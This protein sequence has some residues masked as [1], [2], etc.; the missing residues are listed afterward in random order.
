MLSK[1]IMQNHVLGSDHC[2]C[3]L[4]AHHVSWQQGRGMV[5][6]I[7][8][9]ILFIPC[10]LFA[11]HDL[12]QAA[13]SLVTAGSSVDAKSAI[14]SF[15]EYTT[16]SDLAQGVLR[17]VFG[18][19][20][21]I[22]ALTSSSATVLGVV[23]KG[24][25]YGALFVES[26]LLCY[27]VMKIVTEMN[28]DSGG[29]NRSTIIWTPI[30]CMLSVSLLVPTS[31]GYSMAHGLVM[32]V[33][34]QGIGLANMLWSNACTYLVKEQQALYVSEIANTDGTTSSA[35]GQAMQKPDSSL[36]DPNVYATPIS[37]LKDTDNQ[38][39]NSGSN[40][41]GSAT[42]LRSLLCSYAVAHS[43]DTARQANLSK[44]EQCREKENH[45]STVNTQI[46]QCISALRDDA[47]LQFVA[48]DG[49]LYKDSASDG[50]LY[51]PG[52]MALDN[53][54]CVNALRATCDLQKLT[55]YESQLPGL[56][57]I[58]NYGT[59]QTASNNKSNS[60]YNNQQLAS[61]KREALLGMI[62]ALAGVAQ[63]TIAWRVED[64]EYK[65]IV[66]QY[67][68]DTF[69]SVLNDNTD[70]P[71]YYNDQ[72]N[73]SKSTFVNFKGILPIGSTGS[74]KVDL[75]SA[76]VAAAQTY[77]TTVYNLIADRL[78]HQMDDA[79]S[80]TDPDSVY[81]E[82]TQQGWMFIGNYF[83]KLADNL[84]GI[85]AATT[86]KDSYITTEA[87]PSENTKQL[88]IGSITNL[89]K[90]LSSNSNKNILYDTLLLVN[91]VAPV[92]KQLLT[93]TPYQTDVADS[94]ASINNNTNALVNYKT[95]ASAIKTRSGAK[96]YKDY[97]ERKSQLGAASSLDPTRIS[98][99]VEFSSLPL[100]MCAAHVANIIDAWTEKM[101]DSNTYPIYRLE[102]IG[103]TMIKEV[104]GMLADFYDILVLVLGTSF[105]LPGAYVAAQAGLAF[106]SF[107]GV[108]LGA[109]EV[110]GSMLNLAV[111]GTQM[112]FQ[113]LIVFMPLI[114]GVAIPLFS[115][116]VLLSIY[117]PLIPTLL[118]LFGGISWV[119][120]LLVLLVAAPI[121]CFLMLWS[122]SSQDNPLLSREAEQFIHQLIGAFFRPSLMVI[123]FLAGMMLTYV[124]FDLLNSA[125]SATYEHFFSGSEV[126]LSKSSAKT[127]MSYIG[128][129]VMGIGFL[130]VY[131]YAAVS[132]ANLCFSLIHL[133]YSESMRIVGVMAPAVGLEERNIE[134]AKAGTTQFAEAGAG[135]LRGVGDS[136][137]RGTESTA[138]AAGGLEKDVGG[139]LTSIS[140]D[141][142]T[143][144]IG[145]D[146]GQ[147]ITI[148][149]S[150]GGNGNGG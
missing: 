75:P 18:R 90:I 27:M 43:L 32:L 142:K 46:D 76:L 95:V 150:D 61:T 42:V 116:G 24:L 52:G 19:M 127:N 113:F 39:G 80:T 50:K 14:E 3:A 132:I 146:K 30:K 117:V 9:F 55:D 34:M 88:S 141:N 136:A 147:N 114:F 121:I 41:V 11:F 23:F 96:Q 54:Q 111:A 134:A 15:T 128:N 108:T 57:G 40:K 139:K 126:T 26:L 8:A 143:A 115:F 31:T 5:G 71:C 29:L 22:S 123:G 62:T 101:V 112:G 91:S 1:T 4:P 98:V 69:S 67:I 79:E 64:S 35:I 2:S 10:I 78:S 104:G 72:S 37:Y 81:K 73:C 17:G 120:S 100:Q 66:K 103:H 99:A 148:T 130:G 70:K 68:N 25:S 109:M 56:C 77:Q 149:G 133:L 36:I 140:R 48:T 49:S 105:V 144:G 7:V 28:L 51:I 82:L 110:F 97:S 135:G 122:G 44:L 16:S 60:Y 65:A 87:Q 102:Q 45:S 131:T 129:F 13:S 83:F 86:F 6:R 33:V 59:S 47:P 93:S 145:K 53:Y 94:E 74:L 118:F 21:G 84:N 137:G 20:S 138:G 106:G 38:N 89:N 125:V 92:A 58:F 107:F 63:E 12:A 85:K 119:I 124:G